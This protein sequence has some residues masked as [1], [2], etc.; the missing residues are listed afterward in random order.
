MK[1]KGLNKKSSLSEFRRYV[2]GEMT[3]REENA[4][5]RKLQRDPFA[6]EATEGF[7]EIS[8]RDADDD[9]ARLEKRLK[10]RIRPVR[11]LLYYR[12]AASV[13]VLMVI[14]VIFVIIVRNR[15]FQLLS[16][17]PG[18]QVMMEM[19]DSNQVAEQLVADSKNMAAPEL[20]TEKE[21]AFEKKDTAISAGIETPVAA[22]ETAALVQT[23]KQ[24]S[25]I[26]FNAGNVA[27]PAAASGMLA[28]RDTQVAVLKGIVLAGYEMARKAETDE[29]T[30]IS[31]QPA[32]GRINFDRYIEENMKRP[33]S[34][35]QGDSVIAVVSF[36]VRST[37]E[38]D[39]I[40]VIRNPGDEFAIEAIRLIRE[41]PQWKAAEVKGAPVD[42]EV[43]VRIIFR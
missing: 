36:L 5:Q 21:I 43:Q 24:D 25:E 19:T 9:M 8:P 12:V 42:D 16:K 29:D 28:D 38:V 34:L 41:G 27:A 15:S 6:E 26:Y 14:S 2:R 17:S 7:S 22:E 23:E 18:I 30:Y 40:K 13:A 37:G 4:F 32:S 39:S 33:L 31:A 11:R 3:K 10:E 35:P 20:K 1:R